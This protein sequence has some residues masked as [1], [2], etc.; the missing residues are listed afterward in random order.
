M[1]SKPL[2]Q[3]EFQAKKKEAMQSEP[4]TSRVRMSDIELLDNSYNDGFVKVKGKSVAVTRSFFKRLG[5]ILNIGNK[6]QS[7]LTEEGGGGK[8][9]AKMIDTMRVIRQGQGGGGD[10][11]VIG[12]P[13]TGELTGVTDKPYN[14]I[15]NKDL[16]SIAENVANRYPTLQPTDI[17]V[18][19]GGMTV[20]ISMMS[21]TPIPFAPR[22]AVDD[23]TF[24]F[25]FS[26]DNGTFTSLGDMAFPWTTKSFVNFFINFTMK[27]KTPGR[28]TKRAV[29]CWETLKRISTQYSSVRRNIPC[30]CI[31]LLFSVWKLLS[32]I[33]RPPTP[34]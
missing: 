20:G 18:K 17:D 14:R 7:D 19:D 6:M 26:L 24:Q 21:S 29:S 10:I 3:E 23:E 11:T 5:N 32:I 1:N 34:I 12:N 27:L 8:L 28:L 13:T 25:G 30:K 15:P 9:F 16:F 22:G 33:S 31:P 4:A 2:S